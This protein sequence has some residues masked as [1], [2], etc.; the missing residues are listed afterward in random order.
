M[1]LLALLPASLLRSPAH[2]PA[3]ASS[4]LPWKIWQATEKTTTT[5]IPTK[6]SCKSH[7]FSCEGEKKKKGRN[8]KKENG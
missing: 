4:E 3:S 2:A 7:S 5:T 8:S 1:L 6:C